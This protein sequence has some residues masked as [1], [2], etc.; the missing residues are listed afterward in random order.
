MIRDTKVLPFFQPGP[1][2]HSNHQD[3][4]GKTCQTKIRAVRQ[5]LPA[6]PVKTIHTSQTS[7]TN[8]SLVRERSEQLFRQARPRLDQNHSNQLD[9]SDQL[10]PGRQVRPLRPV[11][12]RPGRPVQPAR[13][14]QSVPLR[15]TEFPIS[16]SEFQILSRSEKQIKGYFNFLKSESKVIL[17]T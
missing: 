6:I 10:L 16:F 15:P 12:P 3:Y 4:S 5:T 17:G 7:Q 9:H 13:Q 2:G 11:K 1:D 8:F 14:K